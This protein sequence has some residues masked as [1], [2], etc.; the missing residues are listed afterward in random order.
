MAALDP[1]LAS[2]NGRT[3]GYALEVGG[4]GKEV[5]RKEMPPVAFLADTGIPVGHFGDGEGRSCG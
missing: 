1:C 5:A 3:N 2:A 4:G